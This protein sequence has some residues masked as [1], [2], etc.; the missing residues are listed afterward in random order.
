MNDHK[1]LSQLMSREVVKLVIVIVVLL[2]IRL[3]IPSIAV[4]KTVNFFSTPLSFL[5]C[6]I[7][8]IDG[9]MLFFFLSFGFRVKTNFEIAHFSDGINMLKWAI[10]LTGTVIAYAVYQPAVYIL[11]EGNLK[12]YN[13]IF[14]IAIV[15]IL[16]K[17]LIMIFVNI[18]TITDLFTGRIKLILIKPDNT[19]YQEGAG[20]ER[21]VCPFCGCS[22]KPGARFCPNDG[23]KLPESLERDISKSI[24]RCPN[25][26][27][28]K[29]IAENAK[30]CRYCG[31]ASTQAVVREKEPLLPHCP[32]CKTI[33]QESAK[34]CRKCGFSLKGV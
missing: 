27:C 6:L 30:F 28:Q 20:E 2:I 14:L 12:T 9:L 24:N 22:V 26:G 16:I 25:P 18:E 31:T 7:A 34:F 13:L 21:V 4:L 8:L 32:Q 15:L 23:K 11:T 19:D 17:L 5:D 3:L 10:L 1:N 29:P 33:V